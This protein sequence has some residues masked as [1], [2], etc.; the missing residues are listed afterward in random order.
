MSDVRRL[1][2]RPHLGSKKSPTGTY[3]DPPQ[4]LEAPQHGGCLGDFGSFFDYR[5]LPSALLGAQE[6]K[7]AQESSIQCT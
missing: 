1:L 5:G 6:A 4:Y 2:M 3:T 7:Q